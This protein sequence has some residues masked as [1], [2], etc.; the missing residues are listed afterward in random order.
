MRFLPVQAAGLM[1]A[2]ASIDVRTDGADTVR[3]LRGEFKV[4]IPL[5]GGRVEK[6]V[7]GDIGTNLEEEADA[8]AE[9]LGI[10]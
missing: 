10:D 9:H 7:V 4:K 6:A 3:E 1:R 5:V 8:V 2:S